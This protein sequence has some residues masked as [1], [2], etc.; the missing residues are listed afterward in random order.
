MSFIIDHDLHIHTQLSSCSNHPEQTPAA[1]LSYAVENHLRHICLADHFWDETVPG[2][3]GWYEPQNYGHVTKALPLPTAEGIRFDFGC[4]TDMNRFGTLGISRETLDRFDFV[5][6]PT[7]HL[8]MGIF[9]VPEGCTSVAARAAYFMER[10]HG[11]LDMDLPFHKMGLAHFT[12]PL[13]ASW[14]EGS[15]DDMLNAITDEAFAALFTRIAACG[16]GVELNTSLE[17]AQSEAAL[18]PY[19]IARDC[20]CKFYLGSDAHSPDGLKH[21]IPRFRA[22]VDALGLTEEDKIPFVR[23]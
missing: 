6:V 5:I 14:S 21:A 12:C 8:H 1:I 17:D 16:L 3:S 19:R 23:G 9:S 7:N 4:E 11:L 15:R 18:R 13:M 10:T 20:G 22:I 2:A